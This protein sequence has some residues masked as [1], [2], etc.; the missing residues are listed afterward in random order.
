VVGV[1][2][3]IFSPSGGS[4][5]LGF[6]IPSDTVQS[7]VT[8]L[9]RDG[10]V[11]RGYLGVQIQ[12][13][14]KELADGLGLS[15]DKGALI[16][17]AQ[18]GT[19]AASAGLTA[20]DVITAV[21]GE[22]VSDAR[23]LSRK[24]AAV[25]PGSKVELTYLRDG[26]QQTASV[27]LGAQP[28]EK[29]AQAGTPPDH[30]SQLGLRLAPASSVPGVGD[31]GVVVVDVDPSGAAAAS[32]IKEG[33]VILEVGGQAVSNPTDVKADLAKAHREEKKVVLLRIE[34][35]E[36]TRFVAINMK[37]VG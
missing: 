16:D 4:V 14:S 8:E 32:G 11:T 3:A 12:S 25:K 26:K 34:S 15:T 6:A 5:G 13:L 20:G 21:N 22:A 30:G 18:D 1:N 29:T 28:E 37:N 2:T 19:P 7:V 9:E 24:I 27:Q 36:G 35:Q 31:K 10:K 33:D 23:E 17:A